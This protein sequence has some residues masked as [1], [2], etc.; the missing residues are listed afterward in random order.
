[1]T[2]RSEPTGRMDVAHSATTP[3]TSRA[4]GRSMTDEETLSAINADTPLNR[5][6]KVFSFE[7]ARIEQALMQRRPPSPIEV[8]R[9]EFEAV[10]KII[11]A[12]ETPNEQ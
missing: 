7:S 2:D 4:E 5:A 10:G 3:D 6:R 12:L 11:A 8:R 9:M 1:M